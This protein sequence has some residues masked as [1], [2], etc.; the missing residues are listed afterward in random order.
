VHRGTVDVQSGDGERTLFQVK[1]P[2]KNSMH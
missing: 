1:V 2:R